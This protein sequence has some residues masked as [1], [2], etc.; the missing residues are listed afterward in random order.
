MP[1]P[2]SSIRKEGSHIERS[3]GLP[4]HGSLSEVT[5]RRDVP[6]AAGNE[7]GWLALDD[8]CSDSSG[9]FL[10]VLSLYVGLNGLLK[11]CA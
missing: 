8:L 7:G 3:A 2:S 9:L 10:I 5:C 4:A 1:M 6:S 11:L